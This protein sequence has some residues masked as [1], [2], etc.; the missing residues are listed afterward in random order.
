MY[1]R[2]ICSTGSKAPIR[3]SCTPAESISIPGCD[4]QWSKRSMSPVNTSLPLV[5]LT[6][7]HAP[8][9]PAGHGHFYRKRPGGQAPRSRTQAWPGRFGSSRKKE[10]ALNLAGQLLIGYSIA[11]VIRHEVRLLQAESRHNCLST[12]WQLPC[13]ILPREASAVCGLVLTAHP[14]LTFS[15][16]AFGV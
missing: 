7:F 9:W 8:G 13:Q 12:A 5:A 4:H 3:G 11:I 15:N 10:A 1:L 2:R 14:S 6:R 16:S